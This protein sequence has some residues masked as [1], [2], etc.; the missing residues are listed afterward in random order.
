MKMADE[1]KNLIEQGKDLE[2][3]IQFFDT[4]WGSY[5]ISAHGQSIDD[6]LA[7]RVLDAKVKR[8]YIDTHHDFLKERKMIPPSI[9]GIIPAGTTPDVIW[10]IEGQFVS[11][12]EG[13]SNLKKVG[14]VLTTEFKKFSE[15]I[16]NIPI[17]RTILE[18]RNFLDELSQLAINIKII[19]DDG[20]KIT[21]YLLSKEVPERQRKASLDKLSELQVK[22]IELTK[23]LQEIKSNLDNKDI[24]G[25]PGYQIVSNGIRTNMDLWVING[26]DT[27]PIN[28]KDLD[29]KIKISI[30][31]LNSVGN[32]LHPTDIQKKL[33]EMIDFYWKINQEDALIAPEERKKFTLKY[34][35]WV[36]V[37]LYRE[38]PKLKPQSPN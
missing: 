32:Y 33:W 19:D 31:F 17:I 6:T 8:F 10:S 5:K 18:T 27:L 16:R 36:F 26:D 38:Y 34:I 3:K 9:P 11:A 4:F 29:N 28:P 37:D 20:I 25:I 7:R 30:L 14:K 23:K 12:L 2:A 1:V 15:C 35:E 13:A 21:Q 22:K 24:K